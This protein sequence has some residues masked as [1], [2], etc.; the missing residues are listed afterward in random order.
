M[1]KPIW[2]ISLVSSLVVALTA[3]SAGVAGAGN[4]GFDDFTP[5]T[6]SAGPAADEAKP[7]TFGSAADLVVRRR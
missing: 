1:K 7:I 3:V 6:S 2:A 5:L 4:T